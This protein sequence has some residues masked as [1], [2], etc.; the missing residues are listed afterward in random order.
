MSD[1]DIL[2]KTLEEHARY[3]GALEHIAIKCASIREA[4]F[5]AASALESDKPQDPRPEKRVETLAFNCEHS[6]SGGGICSE[7]H[8]SGRCLCYPQ[9]LNNHCPRHGRLNPAA[10]NRTLEDVNRE[11][12][13][14]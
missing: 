1:T 2:E 3:K 5:V 8:Q 14:L 4:I 13:G 9:R 11:S 10:Q 7:C 12:K 6:P